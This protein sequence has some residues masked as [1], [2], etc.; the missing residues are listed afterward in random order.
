MWTEFVCLRIV[1]S[2]GCCEHSTKSSGSKNAG[3]FLSGLAIFIFTRNTLFHGVSF[4]ASVHVDYYIDQIE[5]DEM[6]NEC[7]RHRR[8][9]NCFEIL[10]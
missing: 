5:K 7:S 3:N 10:V 6:G 4:L 2:G 8:C 1:S 9:A